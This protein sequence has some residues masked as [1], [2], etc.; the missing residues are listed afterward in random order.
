[1][2]G[3]KITLRPTEA[4]WAIL[5]RLELPEQIQAQSGEPSLTLEAPEADALREALAVVMAARGFDE[6]Y[7]PNA[8]GRLIEDLIDDLFVP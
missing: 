1:M 5:A 6:N 8:E 3:M 7:E 2:S 4:Q